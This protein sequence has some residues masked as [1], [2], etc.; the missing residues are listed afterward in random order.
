MEDEADH[1]NP[2]DAPLFFAPP[3]ARELELHTRLGFDCLET[4]L[5]I[6]PA[7]GEECKTLGISSHNNHLTP[8]VIRE[9]GDDWID[10][11]WTMV[12]LVIP[13][14]STITDP[15]NPEANRKWS[16]A[17]FNATL[18]IERFFVPGDDMPIYDINNDGFQVWLQEWRAAAG[19]QAY[20]PGETEGNAV[21][22]RAE[23]AAYKNQRER[24]NLNLERGFGTQTGVSFEL[25]IMWDFNAAAPEGEFTIPRVSAANIRFLFDVVESFPEQHR[26]RLTVH[27]VFKDIRKGRY[28]HD[29]SSKRKYDHDTRLGRVWTAIIHSAIARAKK[30]TLDY[31]LQGL[32]PDYDAI[33]PKK[34]VLANAVKRDMQRTWGKLAC[35]DRGMLKFMMFDAFKESRLL[36]RQDPDVMEWL[37]QA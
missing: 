2:L 20:G 13:G 33:L 24:H 17:N 34:W 8:D 19:A 3:A 12:D 22:S 1:P 10:F 7:L 26:D 29:A 32:E 9:G 4:T 15:R 35:L 14:E 30:L 6:K 5:E 37:R 25:L 27:F 23:V 18:F 11:Y 36:R 31:E 21:P 28:T 16:N